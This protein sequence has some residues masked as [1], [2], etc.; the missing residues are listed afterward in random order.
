MTVCCVAESASKIKIL[1][2]T[3]IEGRVN[4][5]HE[6]SVPGKEVIAAHMTSEDGQPRGDIHDEDAVDH[7][8]G[9]SALRGTFH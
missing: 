8:L 5:C 9:V 1:I 6:T 3:L 2:L 7:F 4:N